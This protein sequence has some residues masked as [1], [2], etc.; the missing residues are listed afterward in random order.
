VVDTNCLISYLT[1]R[2]QVQQEIISEY[3]QAAADLHARL[4]I[5]CTVLMEMVD[6]F[7][8]VYNRGKKEVAD[9]VDAL[10]Q[11]P[12]ITTGCCPGL[13]AILSVWPGK[14]SRCPRL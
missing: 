5:P 11:T 1:D 9:I 7:V 6:V 4:L 12:G 14:G 8:K 13:S 3:F 2:N 10:D